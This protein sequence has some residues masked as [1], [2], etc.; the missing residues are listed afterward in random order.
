[1]KRLILLLS[2]SFSAWSKPVVLLSY[3]DA[4]DK[5][6]YNNSEII[7]K[8]LAQKNL[9]GERSFELRLC[10]LS[11]VFDKSYAQ[12]ETCL[13]RLERSPLFVLGL[14]E[15]TC[16][17]KLE[18][19]F[20]NRDKTKGPDNE[21]NNREDTLIIPEG[22]VAL[23]P[24]FPLPQMYCALTPKERKKTEIS[25]DAGSF[26]CNNTSYQ[27][28]YYYPDLMSGLIHV[29]AHNC[30]HLERKNDQVIRQLD[31]MIEAAV[32]YLETQFFI[33]PSTPHSSNEIRLPT[34]K[35]ELDILRNEFEKQDKCLTDY[36][37][38]LRGIDEKGFWSF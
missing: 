37:E 6:P 21:G 23:G 28:S 17:L 14:G 35:I 26:V 1:M 4:F 30:R 33:S 15:S 29:P 2:L 3:Y 9:L 32:V 31:L 8:T 16:D 27:L 13:K 7:A 11:T 38:R 10:A 20:R 19:M 18:A 22:P 5:A 34:K 36:F 25:N 24:R 12:L